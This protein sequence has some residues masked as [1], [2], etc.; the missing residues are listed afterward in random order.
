MKQL[1]SPAG[2]TLERLKLMIY[3]VPV[4]G[5]VPAAYSL[6]QK[7]GSRQEQAVSRLV[8]TLALS[9]LMI[10]TLLSAGSHLSPGLSLRLLI[11]NTLV[12]TGYTLTNL[13]LMVRLLQGR[14]VRLP[15]FSRLSDRLP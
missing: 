15:G 10:Y 11:T 13:V 9:W 2:D 8:V 4:F 7:Q 3:L 14:S 5:V 6:W 12:T 1:T